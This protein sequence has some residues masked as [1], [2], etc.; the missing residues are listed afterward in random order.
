[1]LWPHKHHINAKCLIH[2]SPC[3]SGEAMGYPFD[4]KRRHP[5][6]TA[7]LTSPHEHSDPVIQSL[8]HISLLLILLPICL[9]GP[10]PSWRTPCPRQELTSANRRERCEGTDSSDFPSRRSVCKITQCFHDVWPV[11]GT[12]SVTCERQF[13]AEI[14]SHGPVFST[15]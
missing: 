14:R 7:V 13:P 3:C 6:Q 12:L 2:H 11:V 9:H 1:M 5:A 4:L 8:K 15:N 10:I